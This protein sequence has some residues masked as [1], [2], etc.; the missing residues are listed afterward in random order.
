MD[1]C[2]GW[3]NRATWNVALWI[4]N[5]EPLY[6]AAVHYMESKPAACQYRR[7]VAW[8]GLAEERTPD[9]FKYMS[10]R[11]DY[12]ALNEMMKDLV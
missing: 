4:N 9:G 11:L 1:T 10:Q 12:P 7:F 3:K 6:R 5:D 8:A 2:N